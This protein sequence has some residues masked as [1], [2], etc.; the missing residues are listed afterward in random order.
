MSVR[1]FGLIP[2]LPSLS[3]AE[4]H[5]HYRHPHGTHGLHNPGIQSYVQSHRLDTEFLGAD[6]QRYD[7]I[8]EV[9]FLT[10]AE[11]LGLATAE[12]YLTYLKDDEDYF[13]DLPNLKWLYTKDTI[14]ERRASRSV[15]EERWNSQRVPTS[16][17]LL[18]FLD[19]NDGESS[20][21]ESDLAFSLG[22]IHFIRSSPIAEVYAET[23]PA[24]AAVREL[25]W[26]TLHEAHQGI[27]EKYDSW[28]ALTELSGDSVS[29]IARA[30]RFL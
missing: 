22:A 14:N 11:G 2:R 10:V 19:E 8:A 29:L 26:P 18:Q 17:K 9:T 15:A 7:A 3:R 25:W 4:F 28:K 21:D 27:R 16:I 23:P 20:V 30:E 12:N 6:Q 1:F 24:Y 5:D 13:V